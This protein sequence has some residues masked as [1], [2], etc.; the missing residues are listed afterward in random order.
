M[1]IT[2]DDLVEI[3]P[4]RI[5]YKDTSY[6]IKFSKEKWKDDLGNYKS[7]YCIVL[8][9]RMALHNPM[10]FMMPGESYEE[11]DILQNYKISYS[12]NLKNI[13]EELKENNK[14]IEHSPTY[15][16]DIIMYF[17]EKYIKHKEEEGKSIIEKR[18][19]L[20]NFEKWDGVIKNVED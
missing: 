7:Y 3:E 10:V 14:D 1:M 20:I 15:I 2:L 9:E 8:F 13:I 16:Q 18:E 4:K 12:Y 17:L 5:T 6:Y 11:A 19:Q